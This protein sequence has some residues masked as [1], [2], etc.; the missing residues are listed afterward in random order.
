[1]KDKITTPVIIG[2]I[3]GA[4]ALI[5]VIG[6]F[7]FRPAQSTVSAA[8]APTYA[9]PGG[10]SSSYGSTYG[11]NPTSQHPGGMSSPPG[12]SGAPH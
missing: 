4:L 11:Q 3:V 12:A 6:Y 1:M 8:D 7:V 2:A 5:A 9:K 10:A